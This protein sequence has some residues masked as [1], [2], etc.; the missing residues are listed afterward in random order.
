MTLTVHELASQ[1]LS[2]AEIAAT[3]GLHRTTVARRLQSEGARPRGRPPEGRT[4]QVWTRVSPDEWSLL[5]TAALGDSCTVAEWVRSRIL[6][7]LP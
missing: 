5:V 6:Q 4:V 7:A 2:V 3:L 1:G